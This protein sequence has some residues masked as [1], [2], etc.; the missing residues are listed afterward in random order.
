MNSHEK[1][2]KD[3]KKSKIT[4]RKRKE[5]KDKF[6]QLKRNKKTRNGKKI[7]RCT[8]DKCSKIRKEKLNKNV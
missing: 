6:K 4:H 5:E 3:L 7:V 1:Y 8:C 2:L